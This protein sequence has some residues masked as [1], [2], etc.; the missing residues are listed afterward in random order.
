LAVV[1]T[2]GCGGEYVAVF[3]CQLGLGSVGT[4]VLGV[5]DTWDVGS[6][7]LGEGSCRNAA[8][9][10]LGAVL[11]SRARRLRRVADSQFGHFGVLTLLSCYI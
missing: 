5:W 11:D 10:G 2:E 9:G 7:D 8:V 3:R 6:W 4:W 1:E